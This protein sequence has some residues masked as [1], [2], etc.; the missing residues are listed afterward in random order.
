[1]LA[2]LQKDILI[3]LKKHIGQI[4]TELL[5]TTTSEITQTGKL[6]L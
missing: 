3:E 6:P 2:N 5:E 4:R 1:M